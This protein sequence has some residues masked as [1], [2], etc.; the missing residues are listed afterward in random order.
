MYGSNNFSDFTK[1]E[2]WYEFFTLATNSDKK[3]NKMKKGPYS[4]ESQPKGWKKFWRHTLK[5]AYC[6]LST[7][8]TKV[9]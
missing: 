6:A 9:S 8:H 1:N 5:I 3:V 7:I 4:T 2:F